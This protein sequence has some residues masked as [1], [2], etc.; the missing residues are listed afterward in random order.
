MDWRKLAQRLARSPQGARAEGFYGA[1]KRAAQLA[2]LSFCLQFSVSSFSRLFA[3]MVPP[4]GVKRPVFHL[5]LD[6]IV[7]YWLLILLHRKPGFRALLKKCPAKLLSRLRV[8]LE[9][10][11]MQRRPPRYVIGQVNGARPQER[12]QIVPPPNILDHSGY[13]FR[14]PIGVNKI[15]N[16]PEPGQSVSRLQLGVMLFHPPLRDRAM[17]ANGPVNVGGQTFNGSQG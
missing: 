10:K 2:A 16:P 14:V 15:F 12:R 17:L 5:R 7:A 9:I 11:L 3:Q 8:G 6:F 4:P 13:A 1:S